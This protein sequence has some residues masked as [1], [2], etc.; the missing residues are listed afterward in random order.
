MSQ[1]EGTPTPPAPPAGGGG[2]GNDYVEMAKKDLVP[3]VKTILLDPIDGPKEV[4]DRSPDRKMMAIVLIV[5]TALACAV[6]STLWHMKELDAK[7]SVAAIWKGTI[8]FALAFAAIGAAVHGLRKFVEKKDDADLNDDLFMGGIVGAGFMIFH[9]ALLI[10]TYTAPDKIKEAKGASLKA[11]GAMEFLGQDL[12]TMAGTF[13][14]SAI[15]AL[16]GW[17][18][19]FLVL[20]NTMTKVGKVSSKVAFWATPVV[21]FIGSLAASYA[22][23]AIIGDKGYEFEQKEGGGGGGGGGGW[24]SDG[25]W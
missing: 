17:V 9:V 3:N 14:I 24:E 6:I 25:D 13:N 23:G 16:T 19:V 18:L 15:V 10:S 11:Q 2:G 21:I 12:W 1:P 4:Y 8:T 5:G 20:F 7:F 22:A